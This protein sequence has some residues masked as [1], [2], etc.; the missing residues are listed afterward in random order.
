MLV[1]INQ[2]GRH[3]TID[4]FLKNGAVV[5]HQRLSLRKCYGSDKNQQ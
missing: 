3:I 2:L 1:L 4:D 5:C